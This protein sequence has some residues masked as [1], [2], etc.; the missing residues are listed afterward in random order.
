MFLKQLIYLTTRT[1]SFDYSA[2]FT[3]QGFLMIISRKLGTMLHLENIRNQHLILLFLYV[4]WCFYHTY[5][6]TIETASNLPLIEYHT[7]QGPFPSGNYL[8][9]AF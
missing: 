3:K 4:Y 7:M 6:W 8:C 5:I 2:A 1:I 9:W